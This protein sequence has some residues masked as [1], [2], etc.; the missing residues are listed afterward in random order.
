M[1]TSKHRKKHKIKVKK[2]KVEIA[3]AKNAYNKQLRQYEMQVEK[4][5]AQYQEHLANGGKPEDFNPLKE[6]MNKIPIATDE[7]VKGPAEEMLDEMYKNNIE[8]AQ[9]IENDESTEN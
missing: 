1:P 2:R 5:N 3:Q 6:L 9:I 7:E 4:M 8:E